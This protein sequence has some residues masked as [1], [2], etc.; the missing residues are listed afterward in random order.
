MKLGR[1]KDFLHELDNLDADVLVAD[2]GY[3]YEVLDIDLDPDTQD[4]YFILK[5]VWQMQWKMI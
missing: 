1:L 3:V 2:S 4:I 5:T